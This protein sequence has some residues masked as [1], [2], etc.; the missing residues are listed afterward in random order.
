MC[1]DT[2][3]LL[4]YAEP[5]TG[6]IVLCGTDEAHLAVAARRLKLASG[7]APVASAPRPAYRET[8]TR[9][10][11]V[12]YTHKKIVG[13]AG[14]YARVK[15]RYEPLPAGS[16][17]AFA[18]EVVHGTLPAE[19]ILA[20]ETATRASLDNGVAAGFPV[21]DFR[22]VLCYGAYHDQDSST[23]TFEIAAR[24]AFQAGLTKATPIVLEPIMRVEITT[25]DS[26]VDGV[27]QD[28]QSRRGV[29][30]AMDSREGARV[31]IAKVP[32]AEMFGYAAALK[33]VAPGL[34]RWS[35]LFEEYAPIPDGSDDPRFPGA[36]GARI[37]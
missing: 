34:G 19:F 17:F 30:A 6:R 27:A 7:H 21:I 29:V 33:A 15:M 5:R 20:V 16:G 14:E 4:T 26:N 10:G 37:A 8:I 9:S 11:S 3:S 24:A 2:S 22:A 13:A 36:V 31:I 32:L 28:L 35:M 25:P 18:S 23:L 12:D 1:A